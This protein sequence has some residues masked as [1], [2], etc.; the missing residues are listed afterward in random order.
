MLDECPLDF[1]TGQE[2]QEAHKRESGL[3]PPGP[4]ELG[5]GGQIS[6]VIRCCFVTNVVS[7]KGRPGSHFACAMSENAQVLENSGG[8]GPSVCRWCLEFEPLQ[9]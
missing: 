2:R 7:M 8:S 9:P 4:P 5:C 3:E 6:N 1:F